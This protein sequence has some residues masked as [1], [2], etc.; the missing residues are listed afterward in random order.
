MFRA[1]LSMMYEHNIE[2]VKSTEMITWA[3]FEC[4]MSH[5]FYMARENKVMW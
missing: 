2:H 5:Q 4:K 1:Y 3:I